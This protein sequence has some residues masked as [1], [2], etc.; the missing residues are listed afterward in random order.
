[1]GP[2]PYTAVP[3]EASSVKLEGRKA[4]M[5]EYSGP[6]SALWSRSPE[7]H[8]HPDDT[9]PLGWTGPGHLGNPTCESPIIWAPGWHSHKELSCQW[10][11]CKRRGFSPWVRKISCRRKWQPTPVFL[12]ETS[13]GQRSLAG[14]SPWGYK[15]VG[16]DWTHT[17]GNMMLAL[18]KKKEREKRRK[19]GRERERDIRGWGEGGGERGK[20]KERKI[21]K[22]ENMGVRE[23][24]RE[25][26]E[27][28]KKERKKNF[29]VKFTRTSGFPSILWL[30]FWSTFLWWLPRLHWCLT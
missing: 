17:H 1:M 3:W 24:K 6:R 10:R 28:R 29:K 18:A 23:R 2:S 26:K 7:S 19:R 30:G 16:H 20:E 27:G 22:K 14:Y 9:E 5:W 21:T 13:H 8:V 11:R 15:T 4:C 12:P 25:K